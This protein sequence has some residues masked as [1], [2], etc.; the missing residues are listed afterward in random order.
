MAPRVEAVRIAKAPE[1]TPG[2]H[3]RILQGILGP[4]DVAQDP[5]GDREQ[6]VAADA[7]QVDKCLPIPAAGR[8]HEIAIHGSLPPVCAHRV[9]RPTLLVGSRRGRVVH[10]SIPIANGTAVP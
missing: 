5:L 10:S 1:V 9:R 4:I 3:Q 8:L 7:D 2:D 6:P